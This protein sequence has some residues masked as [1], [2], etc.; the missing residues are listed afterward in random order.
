MQTYASTF[1]F[2]EDCGERTIRIDT[3]LGELKSTSFPYIADVIDAAK[4]AWVKDGRDPRDLREAWV[5]WLNAD[6]DR[7]RSKLSTL[8]R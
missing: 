2:D 4:T 7:H 1:E 6:G 3:L 8:A 5:E